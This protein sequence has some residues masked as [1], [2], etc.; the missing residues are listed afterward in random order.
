MDR[1]MQK[2]VAMFCLAGIAVVAIIYANC[3]FPVVAGC[4]GAVAALGGV[5][6]GQ[7]SQVKA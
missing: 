1:E 6:F 7:A 4:A 2:V 3:D 5:A